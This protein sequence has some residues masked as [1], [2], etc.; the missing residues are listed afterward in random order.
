[1][2]GS[3]LFIPGCVQTKCLEK[4]LLW[5]K[6]P[7]NSGYNTLN[8]FINVQLFCQETKE[9]YLKIKYLPSSGD[10]KFFSR[11]Q[12]RGMQAIKE[13]GQSRWRI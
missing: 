8:I 12:M 5:D 13:M 10:S 6:N 3:G 1:M 2:D 4:P 7:K 11:I 9:V